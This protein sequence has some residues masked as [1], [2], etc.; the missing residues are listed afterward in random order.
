MDL[1][2]I[3]GCMDGPGHAVTFAL[4]GLIIEL[5]VNPIIEDLTGQKVKGPLLILLD[6]LAASSEIVGILVLAGKRMF[7]TGRLAKAIDWLVD[8]FGPITSGIEKMFVT[9]SAAT[10]FITIGVHAAR[11]DYAG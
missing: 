1:S 10:T 6:A 9:A 4:M 5:L 8:T 11:G 2:P 7:K 3:Q